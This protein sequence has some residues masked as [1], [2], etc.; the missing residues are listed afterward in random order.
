MGPGFAML[1]TPA[2]GGAIAVIRLCG[3]AVP[4]F[5]ARR[6]SRPAEEG[7]L[8]HAELRDGD[9]VIDDVLVH[10]LGDRCV[11]LNVHGGPWV[12]R[13]V[14]ELAGRDAFVVTSDT[15]TREG[16]DELEREVLAAVPLARTEQTLRILFAQPRAWRNIDPADHPRMLADRSLSHLL[17]PPRVAI[18][19]IPNVGKSTLANQLFAQERSITADLPGTT[20]DWV[21]HFANVDGL[22]VTLVDTPGQRDTT[23]PIERQ[24]IAVSRPVIDGADLVLVVLDPTQPLPLQQELLD[25]HP[26][27]LPILNKSD[28]GLLPV[29]RAIPTVA[30]T[31]HGVDALRLA[32]RRQFG[33]EDL[34]P[35]RPRIWTD[36]QRREIERRPGR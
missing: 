24:A 17:N 25:R 11:D 34:T 15:S 1:L 18:V 4:R 9:R 2:G 31:G 21:G 27:A 14:L 16:E 32:I 22:P 28:R 36:R 33:C 30:T 13:S 19:G 23:D 10:R 20:R 5:L 12:V 8:V 29:P 3:D 7:R 6:L 35:G 26:H